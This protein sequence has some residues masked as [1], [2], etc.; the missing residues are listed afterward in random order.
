MVIEI[1]KDIERYKES[2]VMGLTA[3]QLIFSVASIVAGGGIVLLLYRYI[4]LTPSVYV[5]IPVAAPIALGGFYSFNGMGFYE[6]M[7]RKMRML[8]ANRPLVY[9]STEGE[10]TIR[11]IHMEE[12]AAKKREK[13]KDRRKE[14]I[15]KNRK[16][17]RGK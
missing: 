4:G 15:S 10:K 11:E 9:I 6:Y 13:K 12:A 5:A 1:N 14:K 17:R 2:V 8:F 16:G 3:K 7:G